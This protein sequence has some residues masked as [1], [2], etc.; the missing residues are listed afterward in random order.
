MSKL[1]TLNC[2]AAATTKLLVVGADAPRVGIMETSVADAG[3]IR[4]VGMI[5][6][7]NAWPVVG[8]K[9]QPVV[10]AAVLQSCPAG[11]NEEK[12]PPRIAMVGS[13]MIGVPMP[14]CVVRW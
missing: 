12:A 2:P 11:I 4:L 6:P 10:T 7:G 5:F 1:S 3:S 9:M 13:V 14:R 8:S